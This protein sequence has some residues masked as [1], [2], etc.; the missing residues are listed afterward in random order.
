MLVHRS[1][2]AASSAPESGDKAP[3]AYLF[4]VGFDEKLVIRA[5]LKV[6]VKPGDTAVLVYGSTRSG[7]L[8]RAKVENAV[9]NLRAV[10]EGAGVRVVDLQ[11][12]AVSFSDDVASV[13]EYLRGAGPGRVVV[14]LGSGMRYVAF[15]LLLS[16]LLYKELF[17]KGAEVTAHV[18]REDGLYDV[19]ASLNLFRIPAMRKALRA[20]CLLRG[21]ALKKEEVVDA[22]VAAF[23][24]KP[25][26]FYRLLNRLE[27]SGL[28]AAENGALKL[29]EL[30]ETIARVWCSSG[31]ESGG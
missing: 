30:G 12:G 11:I 21:K 7:E 24:M 23:G 16:A 8:E 5:A 18:A 17:R 14:S 10:L 3:V 20:L 19:T 27:K 22:G 4:G 13:V 31:G 29:T 28:V 15:V 9:R 6:G 1:R 25:A 26:T 2:S